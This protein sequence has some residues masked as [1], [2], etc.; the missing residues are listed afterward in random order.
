[1]TYQGQLRGPEAA[2]LGGI[3]ALFMGVVSFISA[4]PRDALVRGQSFS[5][6]SVQGAE[7][8]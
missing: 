7:S 5:S 6:W 4:V 3:K 2:N 8:F 1:M